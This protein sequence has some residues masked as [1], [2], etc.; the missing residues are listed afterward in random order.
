MRDED[1][2]LDVSGPSQDDDGVTLGGAPSSGDELEAGTTLGR[3]RILAPLGQGAMGVVYAAYD[4]RL[5]RRVALKVLHTSDAHGDSTSAGPER[6]A[7]EAQALA[8]LAHPNV[9]AVHDTGIVGGR[10]FVAMELVA[11]VTL[12]Q[13]A[14][15]TERGWRELVEQVLRAGRGLA[16]A[17]AAGLVHRDFKPENVIVGD[18]GRVRVVDFGLAREAGRHQ[19]AAELDSESSPIDQLTREGA[20][21]STPAYMAPEQF[22]GGLIDARTDQ[23]AFCVTIWELVH[24]QRPFSGEGA[25][26]LGYQITRE[27][28][29]DPPPSSAV[30][31]WL[32]RLLRRGLAKAPAERYASLDE[33]LDAIEAELRPAPTRRSSWPFAAVGA[34]AIAIATGAIVW[35]G[36]QD[37][38][39]PCRHAA[40]RIAEVWDERARDAIATAF[41]ASRSPIAEDTRTRVI[42]VLDA[43]AERWQTSH[44]AACEATHVRHEQS[45]A[46]LDLRM[47]CLEQQ[48]QQFGAFV[49]LL[50]QADAAFVQRAVGAAEKLGD[51]SRCDD[52][53][54][55]GA[56]TKLPDDPAAVL[57]IDDLETRLARAR[58]QVQAGHVP[59][60]R[61]AAL[62]IADEAA[63]L[64]YRPLEAEAAHVAAGAHHILK[65]IPQAE[66]A[67][68]RSLAASLAGDHAEATLVAMIL[69]CRLN[70]MA[71]RVDEA[72]RCLAMGEGVLDRTGSPPR[73]TALWREA[74]GLIA[75]GGGDVD[76]GLAALRESI[77]LTEQH[78][79]NSSSLASVLHNYGDLCRTAGRLDEA[80]PALAR[81]VALREEKLGPHH[82][83][84]A[85]SLNSLAIVYI[86][87]GRTDDAVRALERVLEVRKAAFGE[88]HDH[89][90]GTYNNLGVA[91]RKGNRCA[92]AVPNFER[93]IAMRERTLGK[94]DIK[95]VAMRANLGA[96]MLALG[97]LD[98]AEALATPAIAALAAPELAED[99]CDAIDTLA[100]VQA[101]EGDAKAAAATRALCQRP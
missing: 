59:E 13:W 25:A 70:S 23:F 31:G 98:E 42:A 65:E 57:R 50:G 58:A 38:D 17:H 97:R 53:E 93:A 91:L 3:Y 84:V 69:Y 43:W 27:P 11:G 21:I 46:A 85:F 52:V 60:A 2:K 95:V 66:A 20:L 77:E 81:A 67:A 80:E 83:D 54:R 64:P 28:P 16:A 39:E 26:A 34:G 90:A 22:L 8:R 73:L 15:Q 56:V 51:V 36:Q 10:V 45:E 41:I 86:E 74:E 18:D 72:K 33:L 94:D 100:Q 88:E 96:C 32:D 62:A 44:T 61:S 37:D 40:A 12:R 29:S 87:Q 68:L 101:R 63:A 71:G 9:V 75:F 47:R 55:L 78:I 92:E 30:P 7:R 82:P 35:A 99:R 1:R 6:L 79:G 24:R 48:R 4:P 89:V 49:E 14:A 5:D 76:R 19:A